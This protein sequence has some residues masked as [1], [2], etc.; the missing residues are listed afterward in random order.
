MT[1]NVY[2]VILL[3][4]VFVSSVYPNFIAYAESAKNAEVVLMMYAIVMT[5]RESV[6][7]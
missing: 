1:V 5:A 6:I 3:F 4:A 7:A 2:I